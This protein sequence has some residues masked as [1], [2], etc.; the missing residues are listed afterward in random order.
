MLIEDIE[1]RRRSH[2]FNWRPANGYFYHLI[3]FL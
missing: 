2:E 1:T 3:G